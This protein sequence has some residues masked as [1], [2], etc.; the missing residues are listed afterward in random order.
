MEYAHYLLGRVT[1]ERR[2]HVAGASVTTTGSIATRYDDV[3]RRVASTRL[4]GEA[5]DGGL[6][7]TTHA[8]RHGSEVLRVDERG[9]EW[10]TRV[11]AVGNVRFEISPERRVRGYEYEPDGQLK[12]EVSPLGFEDP[13]EPGETVSDLGAPDPDVYAAHRTAYVREPSSGVL[14]ETREPE[15]RVTR[16]DVDR[17]DRVCVVTNAE[18]ETT[19]WEFDRVGRMVAR[20][21]PS[22]SGRH[23]IRRCRS[24]AHPRQS[25]WRAERADQA[26]T[27]GSSP[28]SF[29]AAAPGATPT[30]PAGC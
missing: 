17:L 16:Y 20:L 5:L 28:R 15:G 18:D 13:N 27:D 6:T 25:A 30:I 7:T 21:I 23:R 8:D 12:A 3:L 19:T 10:R 11:D 26:T 29:P 14:L 22:V 4:A 1:L 9:K 2:Q 24:E